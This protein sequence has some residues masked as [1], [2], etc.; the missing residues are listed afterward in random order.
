MDSSGGRDRK[1]K[2]QKGLTLDISHL[3]AVMVPPVSA[4]SSSLST[5]LYMCG[6]VYVYLCLTECMGVFSFLERWG[7]AVCV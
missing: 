6:C 3:N 1:G 4:P 2:E 7:T 5:C